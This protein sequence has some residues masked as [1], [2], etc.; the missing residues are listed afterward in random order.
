MD[1]VSLPVIAGYIVS[2]LFQALKRLSWLDTSDAVVKQVTVSVI[3]GVAVIAAAGW[4]VNQTTL[5]QA[6]GAAIM[7]LATHRT[8]L[9]QT[10]ASAIRAQDYDEDQ[11][12]EVSECAG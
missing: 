6:V 4:Q 10:T 1:I 11:D 2:M 5:L 7:A 3:A 9:A 8:L 12:E